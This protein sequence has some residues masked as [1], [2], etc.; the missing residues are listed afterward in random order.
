MQDSERRIIEAVKAHQGG[1]GEPLTYEEQNEIYG[2]VKNQ[3]ENFRPY[4]EQKLSE[5][6]LEFLDT[7]P[8]PRTWR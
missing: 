2:G 4:D 1:L 7:Q 8:L 3:R 6:F 5:A